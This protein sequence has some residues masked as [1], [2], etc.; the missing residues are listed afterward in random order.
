MKARV[1]K[2]LNIRSGAPAVLADNNPGFFN[3]GEVIEISEKVM[4]QSVNGNNVWYKLSDGGFVW[5]GGLVTV[6]ENL[7]PA[8]VIPP[9]EWSPGKACYD[10]IKTAED[11]RLNAYLD[12]AGIWTIGYGTILYEDS[13]HVKKGDVITPERAEELLRWEVKLKARAVNAATQSVV[14]NQ[15]QYDALVSFTYNT[16]VKALKGSTLLKRVQADPS[17]P[18][19]RNAFMMWNKAHVDGNLVT[20]DGL[21]NRRQKE[22]DLYFS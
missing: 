3:P 15:N 13:T 12:S 2:F 4:G 7:A 14:L 17:D 11:L 9:N 16:G 5:S 18:A 8:I 1:L 19:I 22:A 10:F 21:T 20:L 6:G